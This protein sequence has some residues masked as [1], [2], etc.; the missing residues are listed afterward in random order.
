MKPLLSFMSAIALALCLFTPPA[1]ADPSGPT[2]FGIT[3][4]I[5]AAT[6]NTS[7][8]TIGN[9]LPVSKFDSVGLV[10]NAQGSAS[11]SSNITITFARSLDGTN[12]ETT[13]QLTWTVAANGTTQ[14]IAYTNLS[15]T[16]L[17]PAAYL[18]VVSIANANATANMTN[19]SLTLGTKSIKPSP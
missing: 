19:A 12:Y 6:T 1:H 14:V 9:A 10:F 15:N 3:N 4:S 18:K 16:Y 2:D 8:Q 11:G 5:A 13:P 17:G 7:A